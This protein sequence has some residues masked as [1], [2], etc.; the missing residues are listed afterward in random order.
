MRNFS[1][2]P[3]SGTA[4]IE[5]RSALEDR[6]EQIIFVVLRNLIPV[7]GILFLGWSAQNLIALYFADTLGAMWALIT[8]L[9]LNLPEAKLGKGL[10][11]RA[12]AYATVIFATAFLV[13]FIAIPLGMPLFIYA[14]AVQWDWRA[15]FGDTDFGYGLLV[16]AGLAFVGMLRHYQVIARLTPDGSNAKRDFGILITRWFL[17]MVLIYFA[18]FLLGEL[19][20]YVMVIGYVAAT[21]ASEIFPERFANLFGRNG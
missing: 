13:A 14:M 6:R 2:P 5:L 19:G 16:I 8:A 11:V 3:R 7:V 15:A 18:G 9:A 4:E 21:V 10:L 17:V 1:R 20:A 12:Q